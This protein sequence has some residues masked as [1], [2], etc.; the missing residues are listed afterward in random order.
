MMRRPGP[1]TGEVMSLCASMLR[2]LA[3]DSHPDVKACYTAVSGRLRRPGSNKRGK[4]VRNSVFESDF[5][6]R[7]TAIGEVVRG[8]FL[9]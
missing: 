6:G 7:V 2:M 8:E 4:I 3:H 1:S 9:D 5:F